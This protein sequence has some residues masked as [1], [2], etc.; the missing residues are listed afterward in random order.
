MVLFGFSP[1]AVSPLP[2]IHSAVHFEIVQPFIIP[3]ITVRVRD[4]VMLAH[5]LKQVIKILFNGEN[6]K[7]PLSEYTET[8]NLWR[9]S[10]RHCNEMLVCLKCH[11]L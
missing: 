4:G 1:S 8:R 10:Y 6:S 3:G 7:L 11:D 2:V 9:I 5:V